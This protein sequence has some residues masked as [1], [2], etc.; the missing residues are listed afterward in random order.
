MAKDEE[1]VVYYENSHQN[2]PSEEYNFNN[3][4]NNMICSV[5][6]C[7]CLS[8]VTLAIDEWAH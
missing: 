4:M 7:H 3:Q 1:I 5:D 2:V 8:P 6:S